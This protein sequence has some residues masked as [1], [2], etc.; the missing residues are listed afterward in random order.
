MVQNNE[1]C[2]NWETLG[3]AVTRP[4]MGTAVPT[5]DSG[6]ECGLCGTRFLSVSFVI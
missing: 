6:T 4:N 2:S 3:G 5:L 1:N